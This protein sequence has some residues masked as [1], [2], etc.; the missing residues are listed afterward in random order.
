MNVRTS[1][2]ILIVSVFLLCAMPLFGHSASRF[3]QPD[4]ESGHVLPS[5]TR[6]EPA[7]M[8]VE[9]MDVL[10]LVA[11]LSMASFLALKKRSRI[12][13]FWLG[14]VCL[15]YFG[16]WREGCICP[17]GSTQNIV[18]AFSVPGYAVSISVVAF[19]FIPLLFSLLF[20]RVFCAA[21][22]PLGAIQ[23]M[24]IL[25][26]VR[27]P[28]PLSRALGV[29]AYAYLGLAVLFVINGAGFII[30]RYDP[31]VPLFRLSGTPQMLF[32]GASFLVIGI[33][34]ARPYC[35]FVCPYG[36]L[37]NWTSKLSRRH[38]TI[39]PDD[40]IQCK[41]CEDSC[42]FDTILAPTDSHYRETEGV[43][44]R[45]LSILLAAV[46]VIALLGYLAGGQLGRPL[47]RFHPTVALAESVLEEDASGKIDETIETETFR[48]SG[49]SVGVLRKNAID[50]R[51]GFKRTGHFL[52]LFFG[53]VIG[54][55]LVSL[56]VRRSRTDYVPDRGTCL[57]CGR[58]FAYC[59]EELEGRKGLTNKERMKGC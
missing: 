17:V 1:N 27:V 30:C 40:C 41:L 6:P 47:A 38:L 42:P 13:M 14:V 20:G 49:E 28:R 11:A 39:T 51:S 36:V 43:A 8:L 50:A 56:S 53:L 55:K 59:P 52:G 35:R 16:F 54:C 24:V 21:V 18:A 45:R 25:H 2:R 19:F 4:F 9:H 26:P 29:I 48:A 15:G 34:V 37:L 32:L 10:L 44:R 33:F 58:C 23:D 5:S 7:G 12:G 46:P 31:F 3:P 22:C 57:S